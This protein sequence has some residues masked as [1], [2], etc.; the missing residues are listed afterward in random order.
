[1]EKYLLTIEK[2][3]EDVIHIHA[4]EKGL[5]FLKKEIEFLLSNGNS[6]HTHLFTESWGG[7]ELTETLLHENGT[8]I[9]HHLKIFKWND[10][11]F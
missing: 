9:I 6:D 3:S 5:Q 11:D 8:S 2:E 4:N 10:E 7:D 1:M